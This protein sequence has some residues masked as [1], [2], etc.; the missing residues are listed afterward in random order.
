MVLWQGLSVFSGRSWTQRPNST[1]RHQA[2]THRVYILPYNDA[3]LV[4]FGK[5]GSS[6]SRITSYVLF[7]GKYPKPAPVG[8]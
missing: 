6:L 8:T 4:I 3:K 1:L 7:D 5:L 2:I